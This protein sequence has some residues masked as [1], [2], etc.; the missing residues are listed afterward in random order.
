MPEH[1]KKGKHLTL[2]DRHEIQRGLK[3]H[4]TF[5]EIALMIGCCPDTISKEIRNHRYHKPVDARQKYFQNRCRYRESC[6]KRNICN[7][8]GIHKC[9]IPC[10]QCNGCNERCK[11]FV[12]DPCP[13]E[14]KAP[15]VCN[16]CSKSRSCFFDKY[17]YNADYANREYQEKLRE[18]RQGIDLTKDELIALDELV[19]PLIRKGQPISHILL[20]HAED[21]P[22]SARTLYDYIDKGYLSAR[23]LDL[24]RKV[25]Y[26]KRRHKEEAKPSPLKKIGHHYKDFLRELEDNPGIRVV[27]MDTVIGTKGGKVLQTIYWRGEKLMTAFLIASKEMSGAAESFNI[28]QDRLGTD[29]FCELFP[30]VL[31]DNGTEF[32]DPYLFEFDGN[33]N[34]RMKLFYC[35]PRHSEQ[36][37]EIEKNHEYIRY[38]LPQG[39]SF[40][41]LTQEKVDLLMS[42][43]NSTARPSLQGRTPI[44]LALQHFGK[45][46]VEKLGLHIIKADDV[47]LKP[48]L[49][50]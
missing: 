33:G 25:R 19:S 26:K 20:D 30:V 44:E 47:C 15:Y 18:S 39:S 50:K 49:L 28:L 34:R 43:I 32:A 10:R 3:E 21:I 6:R 31:T 29:I 40:D 17:L 48:D 16:A 22:C 46:T 13:V 38:V 36:K 8:K 27:E 37:G 2:E 23:N 12:D 24:R 35:D 7:K 45:D 42:H 14:K 9:K 4:R 41:D 11:D 1:R 5:T